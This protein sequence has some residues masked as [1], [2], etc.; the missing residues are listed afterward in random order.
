MPVVSQSPPPPIITERTRNAIASASS[1]TGVDF[2]FLV[3]Q[4]RIES[5]FNPAARAAT[6]TATGL[7]QFTKQTWL[8]T[9][10]AH[11]AKHDLGWAANAISQQPSGGYAVADPGLRQAILDL[12]TQPE[13]A[14]AM[15]A[16]LASDNSDFL[17]AKLDRAPEQVDLYL[18]HFLG[19]AGASQFLA[20]HDRSP[21]AA[22]A[23][24]LPQAAAANRP[25][26]Y[27]ADGSSRSF[28]EIRDNFARK[29]DGTYAPL[30]SPRRASFAPPPAISVQANIAK[31]MPQMRG[32]EAMPQRLSLEFA[33]STYQRLASIQHSG[34]T[35]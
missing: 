33:R 32:F 29:F 16:E 2:G 20:A 12:R 5:G 10:K 15:A 6:S 9:L 23:A 14:S 27:N 22:A 17:S 35:Q 19:E 26:F 25:I 30:M 4:A 31:E 8:G 1:K 34:I 11:G 21:D 28:R 3:N 24:A 7:Y 18:A 13:A